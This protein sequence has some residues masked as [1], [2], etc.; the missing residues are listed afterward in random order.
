MTIEPLMTPDMYEQFMVLRRKYLAEYEADNGGRRDIQPP[1]YPFVPVIGK[2][3]KIPYR[4]LFIGQATTG[5]D[6]SGIHDTFEGS[7]H[8]AT[9][10]LSQPTPGTF[11]P[12]VR[13]VVEE[14]LAALGVPFEAED[15]RKVVAWSNLV[16]V[17]KARP[18]AGNGSKNPFGPLVDIQAERC[19]EQIRYEVSHC[20]PHA[21]I[22]LTS[23]YADKE[24]LFPA[25][26][27]GNSWPVSHMC[28]HVQYRTIEVDG[29]SAPAVWTNHPRTLRFDGSEAEARDDVVRRTVEALSSSAA[30][31]GTSG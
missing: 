12:F 29:F 25:F 4:F 3:D 18:Y 23:N 5:W 11:W 24:I 6:E 28:E 17:G 9:N 22:I 27:E 26:G 30:T 15:F 2:S 21:V 1:A 16:K 7:L 8:E 19:V 13:K 10:T 31:Y 14:S 20:R